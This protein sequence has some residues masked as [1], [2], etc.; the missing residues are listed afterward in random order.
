MHP[1][2]LATAASLT[3]E[4]RPTKEALKTQAFSGLGAITE[5]PQR[6]R[7]ATKNNLGAS[8]SSFCV[9]IFRWNKHIVRSLRDTTAV[10]AT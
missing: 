4:W 2:T 1:V 6:Q 7:A 9:K 3:G 8:T 10:M 5:I